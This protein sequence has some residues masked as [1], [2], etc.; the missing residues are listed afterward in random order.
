MRFSYVFA[1]SSNDPNPAVEESERLRIIE[2]ELKEEVAKHGPLP[3]WLS[4]LGLSLR[5]SSLWLVKGVPWLEVN[6][7]VNAL[8]AAQ[9]QCKRT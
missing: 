6:H 2:R 9:A 4:T 1:P 3:S 5:P 8:Y 7:L